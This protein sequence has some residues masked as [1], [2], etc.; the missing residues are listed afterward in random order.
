[1]NLYSIRDGNATPR[2]RLLIVLRDDGVGTRTEGWR[3]RLSDATLEKVSRGLAHF[4]L[5]D[6][7]RLALALPDLDR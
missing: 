3:E 4:A 7:E 5:N 6:I 1:V 2:E